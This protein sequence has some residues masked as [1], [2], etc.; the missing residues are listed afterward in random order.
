MRQDNG[1]KRIL[2]N[3]RRVT[4]QVLGPYKVNVYLF[5]SW[6]KGAQRRTSD[7]DIAVD[8]H[9]PLPPGTLAI[10]RERFEE[11]RIPYRVEVVDLSEVDRIFRR[12]VI[13][14]GIRWTA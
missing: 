9:R 10:L 6:A 11:S 1:R 7:I 3:V 2:T 5:G 4:R 14:Q 12:T 13:Q 8:P